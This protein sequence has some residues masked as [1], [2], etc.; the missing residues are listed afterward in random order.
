MQCRLLQGPR[1]FPRPGRAFQIPSLVQ[2]W[3]A[4]NHWQARAFLLFRSNWLFSVL[5][6]MRGVC[7]AASQTHCN[8]FSLEIRFYAS[9]YLYIFIPNTVPDCMGTFT[10]MRV[11]ATS[12][13]KN[14]ILSGA[15]DL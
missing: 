3:G 12:H 7:S 11:M 10:E 13:L 4:V 5:S 6:R 8:K 2:K 14:V 9:S 1:Q 15:K